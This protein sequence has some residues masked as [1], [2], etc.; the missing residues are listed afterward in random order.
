MF[1]RSHVT[2][3]TANQM[4]ED[5]SDLAKLAVALPHLRPDAAT[6]CPVPAA[7]LLDYLRREIPFEDLQESD[8]RFERTAQVH[9]TSYWLWTLTES[10][11]TPW[12]ASVARSP[13]GTTLGCEWNS[14]G[15]SCEQYIVG[16]FHNV[17]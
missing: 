9:Q 13:K 12:F 15:L 1:K 5:N 8:L 3:P 10:D 17:F 14:F 16:D 6:S 4:P 11:G 2:I 7:T